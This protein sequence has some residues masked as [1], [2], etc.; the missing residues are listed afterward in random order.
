MKAFNWNQ[1]VTY[2]HWQAKNSFHATA[3]ARLRALADLIPLARG[4]YDIRSNKAGIAVSGEITLHGESL[5]LQVSQSC[6]GTNGI[7]LRECK[8]RKDYSGGRNHFLPLELLNDLPELARHCRNLLKAI[9]F[10]R[11]HI[12]VIRY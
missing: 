1:R 10:A 5:Y 2:E 11:D 4:S 8:G 6:M 7:M 12:Q 3:R 9:E